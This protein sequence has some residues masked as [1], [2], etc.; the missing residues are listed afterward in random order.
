MHSFIVADMLGLQIPQLLV[1]PMKNTALLA[2][3]TTFSSLLPSWH[4]E[5]SCLLL[6]ESPKLLESLLSVPQLEVKKLSLCQHCLPWKGKEGWF[7]GY[8]KGVLLAC[9]T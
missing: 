5:N 9:R 6:L 8:F 7:V 3:T 4:V 1:V 2:R